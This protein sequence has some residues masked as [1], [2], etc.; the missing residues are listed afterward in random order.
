MGATGKRGW[1]DGMSKCLSLFWTW[2]KGRVNLEAL[3][4]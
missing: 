2:R 4:K 1:K 3:L